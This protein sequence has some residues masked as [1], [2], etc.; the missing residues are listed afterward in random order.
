VSIDKKRLVDCPACQFVKL[1]AGVP[2]AGI[3]EAEKS[4]L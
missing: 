3:V 2:S 4:F 1:E